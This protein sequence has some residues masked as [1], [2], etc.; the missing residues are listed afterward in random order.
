MVGAVAF[1][2]K[3]KAFSFYV[4]YSFTFSLFKFRFKSMLFKILFKVCVA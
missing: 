2:A 3:H 1:K 4:E